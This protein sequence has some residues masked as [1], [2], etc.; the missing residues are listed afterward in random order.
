MNAATG[1]TAGPSGIDGPEYSDRDREM[2]ALGCEFCDVKRRLIDVSTKRINGF[3][4]KI[5]A[6]NWP[7]ISDFAT[8][9]DLEVKGELLAKSGWFG[10]SV[11]R[12]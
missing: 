1:P 12:P 3:T 7:R 9:L 11:R 2:F 10:L 8:W 4:T 6:E 5:H